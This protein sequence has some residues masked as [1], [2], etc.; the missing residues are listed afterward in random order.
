MTLLL[1]EEA[2]FEPAT[3]WSQTRCAAGLRYSSTSLDSSTAPVGVSR[4][5]TPQ[6][7]PERKASD[8]S[9]EPS[10]DLRAAALMR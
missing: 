2:G 6:L 3:T 1:V 9:N 4:D 5:L 10:A 7:L 8:E